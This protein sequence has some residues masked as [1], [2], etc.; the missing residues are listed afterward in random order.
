MN[1]ISLIDSS[2]SEVSAFAES[3]SGVML[4]YE[5]ATPVEAT[6]DPPLNMSYPTEQGGT[7]SIVIPT[8]EMSAAPTMAVVYAYNADGVR[9]LSQAIIANIEGNTASTNYAIGGY[10]VHGG[11]LY[12]ATS[13]IATG[14]TINPGTN[15]VQ[16]TVMTELLALTA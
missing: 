2:Y 16:T 10:F 12:K 4:Y 1:R 6:I 8:G 5:L 13:A 3:V 11:K 14:E 15:C 7:E 9:D